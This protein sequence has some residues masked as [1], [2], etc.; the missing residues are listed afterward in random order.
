MGTLDAVI[1]MLPNAEVVHDFFFGGHK[2]AAQ[3]R[4][5]SWLIDC[6]TIGPVAARALHKEAM[7]KGHAFFDAPVSG[8]VKGAEEAKLTFMVGGAEDQATFD[9]S[10][11]GRQKLSGADG[12]NLLQLRQVGHG[13]DG[14][15]G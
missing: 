8:G 9:V 13:S 3:L 11:K 7:S 15:D 2:V 4:P 6:S 12:Q 5:K 1:T 14:Q 10:S